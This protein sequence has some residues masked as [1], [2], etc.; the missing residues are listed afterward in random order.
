MHEVHDHINVLIQVVQQ[1]KIN[2]C[3]KMWCVI[4]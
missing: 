1:K 4:I 3:K 2:A